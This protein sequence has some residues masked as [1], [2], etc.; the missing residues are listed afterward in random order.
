MLEINGL[1]A[2]YGETQILYD[3]NLSLEKN[4]VLSILG[5]NGVGKTTLLKAIMQ[6]IKPYKNQNQTH[7]PI[8]FLGHDLTRYTTSNAA[9]LGIAYV[10]ETRDIFPSLSVLENLQIAERLHPSSTTN[11]WDLPRVLDA[12]PKLKS[13]LNHAGKQLSGGEQQMLAIAR[14]LIFN[15]TLLILDEPSEGLAPII[16]DLIYQQLLQI[17]QHDMTILLVEQ[18]FNFA[19]RLSDR[20]AIMVRGQII[21][22]GAPKKIID[23]H[24][25]RIKWLGI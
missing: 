24:D 19:T 17:K 4:T 11:K 9:A 10:P 23:D 22:Q 2:G 15:P 12:F 1:N 13:R 7:P 8:R 25:F 20:A 21:W 3:I 18:N 14:A 5:R 6:L 16:V